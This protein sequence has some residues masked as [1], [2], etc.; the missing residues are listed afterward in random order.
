MKAEYQRY[1]DFVFLNKRLI[2]TRF[3][4]NIIIFC[5]INAEGKT[6]VFALAL[7]RE[8]SHQSYCFAIK[9]FLDT[10]KGNPGCFIIERC[11]LMRGMF[12]A[13]FPRLRLYFC[14]HNLTKTVKT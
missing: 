7:L 4:R 1:Q 10:V 12:K 13:F 5:G 9:S 14:N 2:K 11:S 3:R 6:V 8:E